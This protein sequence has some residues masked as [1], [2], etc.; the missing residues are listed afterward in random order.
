[1]TLTEELTWRGFVNQTTF[2]DGGATALNG[3]PIKFYWGVDPSADSMTIG[4]LAA[5]M[6]VHHFMQHGHKA[7]LLIGGATGLIGDPDGK[8]QERDLQSPETIADNKAKIIAQYHQLF[9]DFPF[10]LV[11]NYDWFKGLGYLDFLR[12]VGK[13]VPLTQMLGREFVKSRLAENGAGLSYAEFSYVLIQA[14]DF[15]KL[16]E[17]QQVTL[18]LCGS[19]QWG[20]S[21]AGVDLIRRKTGGEAHVYSTPLVVNKATGQKFGK[22]EAGAIWLDPKKTTPTQFYQFWVN[23]DDDGVEDYLKIFTLLD[24]T[25]IDGIMAEQRQNPGTRIA[26]IKLAEEVTRLVHGQELAERA[27]TTTA[28]LTG[29][30]TLGQITDEALLN[31]LR[32]EIPNVRVTPESEIAQ[33]LVDSG[34]ATSK[35]T[36]RQLLMSNAISFNGQK[37]KREQFEPG[38]FQ[39]GRLLIRRGKAFK[40]SALVEL[41]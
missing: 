24:K 26:Q 4:N 25:T 23:L 34:L 36:A 15:L 13:H 28:I 9:A 19:D 33:A 22:S 38:D 39:N 29:K 16:Y 3:Q 10:E 11:D 32:D 37:V 35:T 6:L 8:S 27:G 7:T 18:Q 1:M 5:A 31:E 14:Y 30:T 12:D 2:E 21:I 20:N 40:D 17:D 41:A